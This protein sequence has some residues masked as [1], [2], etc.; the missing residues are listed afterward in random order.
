MFYYLGKQI[1]LFAVE[2]SIL[3]IIMEIIILD[4]NGCIKEVK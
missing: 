1:A 3:G 4:V 2:N